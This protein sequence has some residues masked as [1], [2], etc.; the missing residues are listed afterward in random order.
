MEEGET[1]A[2]QQT[3]LALQDRM[4]G[5]L[6]KIMR[7]VDQTIS[8][9]ERMDHSST[10]LDTKGLTKARSGL[11]SASAEMERFLSASRT[12]KANGVDPLTNRFTEMPGPIGRATGAVKSFFASF[13]GAA[14]AYLSIQ[15]IVNGF[16]SF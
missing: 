9:M 3:S 10:N 12:A 15:G 4:T 2:G 1:M 14:T 16:K 13:A 7:A 8:V 6:M 11:Q 5:P